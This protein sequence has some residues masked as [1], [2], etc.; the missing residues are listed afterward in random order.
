MRTVQILQRDSDSLLP[1]SL[2]FGDR[3]YIFLLIHIC[4][5]EILK[6]LN[7]KQNMILARKE[8]M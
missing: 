5:Y 8:G 2:T 7:V 1:A 6:K 3:K 4:L